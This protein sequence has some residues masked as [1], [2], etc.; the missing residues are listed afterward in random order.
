M[1]SD[2][3]A[4]QHLMRLAALA[5]D[6]ELAAALAA[7]TAAVAPAPVAETVRAPEIGLVMVQGR[8][9]GDGAPFNLG[10]ATVTRAVVRLASGETGH[11]YLLGRRIEGARL[12]ATIDALG[13]RA[14]AAAILELAF[15][16]P[17]TAR[18]AAEAAAAAADTAR[19]RV[20]F[21]TLQR[22]ENPT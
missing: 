19:T 1:T 15:V 11:A 13:Q 9:G 6:A 4:R 3:T 20:Q 10:E 8:A 7:V 12:A 17:V 18:R 16:A 2:T 22:G 21:F 5:T 14:D